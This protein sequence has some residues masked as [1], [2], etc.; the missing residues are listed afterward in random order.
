MGL[1]AWEPKLV[2]LTSGCKIFTKTRG[3]QAKRTSAAFVGK[4]SGEKTLLVRLKKSHWGHR[5]RILPRGLKRGNISKGRGTPS[6]WG[7]R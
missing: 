1:H 5:K 6:E 3:A 7:F 2:V 4:N